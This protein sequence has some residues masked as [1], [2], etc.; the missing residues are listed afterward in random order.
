MKLRRGASVAEMN[1][2]MVSQDN[3]L[4]DIFAVGENYPQMLSSQQFLNLQSEIAK[5]N[6][7]LAASITPCKQNQGASKTPR[8]YMIAGKEWARSNMRV[9]GQRGAL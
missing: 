4:R 5:E 8:S 2:A 6:D 3:A 9:L 7:Q 1:D